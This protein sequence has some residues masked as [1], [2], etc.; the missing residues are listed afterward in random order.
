MAD[1]L[2]SEWASPTTKGPLNKHKYSLFVLQI[3]IK[4]IIELE[5]NIDLFLSYNILQL[6]LVRVKLDQYDKFELQSLVASV[7]TLSPSSH[8]WLRMQVHFLDKWSIS[9]CTPI[10]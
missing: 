9:I 7:G 2:D 5:E 10:C 6:S 3:L 4:R 8:S 1:T